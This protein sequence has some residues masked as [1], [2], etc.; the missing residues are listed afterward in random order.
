MLKSIKMSVSGLV[1]AI[2]G[3]ICVAEGTETQR[4]AGD[5]FFSVCNETNE[6]V[7]VH[8]VASWM[9]KGRMTEELFDL[10]KDIGPQSMS[11][12]GKS[13]CKKYIDIM[14]SCTMQE[15]KKGTL[16]GSLDMGGQSLSLSTYDTCGKKGRWIYGESMGGLPY[17]R[18]YRVYSTPIGTC[19]K[20]EPKESQ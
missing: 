9:P 13:E 4:D 5:V 10:G 1:F 15:G 18:N 2:V 12:F 16:F 7:Q 17:G 14:N 8:L 11:H 6:S 20:I 19:I 3:G